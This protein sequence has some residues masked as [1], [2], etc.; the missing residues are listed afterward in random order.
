VTGHPQGSTATVLECHWLLLT[1]LVRYIFGLS[2]LNEAKKV[3]ALMICDLFVVQP[4]QLFGVEDAVVVE[5]GYLFY[6]VPSHI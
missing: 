6:W 5:F 1:Q 3:S 2:L 4:F